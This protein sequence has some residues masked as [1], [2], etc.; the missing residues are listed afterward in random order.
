MSD[1]AQPW[2][3]GDPGVV[4]TKAVASATVIEKGDLVALNGSNLPYAGA[5]QTWDTN[6]ATTQEAFHDAFL[7]VALDR[8]PAGSTDP[9][10][11][12]TRGVYLFDC[13]SQ[14]WE[15]GVLVGLD[16]NSSSLFSKKVET[17]ASANLAIGRV[18]R[19]EG[20]AVTQVYVEVFS[21]KML[22]GPQTMM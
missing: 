4:E 20:T 9:I 18:A 13:A 17:V 12:G 15:L 16:E 14:T 2:Q 1:R 5:D 8:S 21:T 11:V 7:G 3:Y 10:R 22:G 6:L 19:R